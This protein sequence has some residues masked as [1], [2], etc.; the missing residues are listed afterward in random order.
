RKTEGEIF[1]NQP[2]FFG[3][4]MISDIY[5]RFEKG[6]VVE[7]RA[8]RGEDLLKEMIASPNADKIGEFSLTDGRLSKITKFMGTTLYDEN[9]GGPE[10]NTHIAVGNAYTD[11]FTGD[12]SGVTKERW[13]E[14]GYNE[15][16]VHT[17]IISTEPRTV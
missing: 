9:M 16:S 11:S 3:G 14:M 10:G 13:A 6:W 7:S 8:G 2:L 15:S 4:N 17:D 12:P 1:F 5:L